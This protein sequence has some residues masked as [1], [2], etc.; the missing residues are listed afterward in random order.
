MSLQERGND[1]LRRYVLKARERREAFLGSRRLSKYFGRRSVQK[2]SWGR[3]FTLTDLD[4]SLQSMTYRDNIYG[5]LQWAKACYSS[6]SSLR[7]P[8]SHVFWDDDESDSCDGMTMI[9]GDAW[10]PW[11]MEHPPGHVAVYSLAI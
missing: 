7:S 5:K 11:L 4:I 2:K 10:S 9:P 3:S 8:L 1:S 6:M